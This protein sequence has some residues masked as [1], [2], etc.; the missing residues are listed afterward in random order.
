MAIPKIIHS[1]WLGGAEK[2]ALVKRCEASWREHLPDYTFME[3]NERNLDLDAYP[4]ARLMC[5]QKKWAFAIDPLRLMVLEKYGGI[6]MDV[7]VMVKKSFNPLLDANFIIGFMFENALGA[8]VVA[9]VPESRIVAELL[10]FYDGYRGE[11]IISNSIFTWY[12]V[13]HIEGFSLTGKTQVLKEG[14]HVYHRKYFDSPTYSPEM[15]YSVNENLGSWD[16]GER[17]RFPGW[18]KKYMRRLT[19]PV[20]YNDLRMRYALRHVPEFYPTYMLHKNGTRDYFVPNAYRSI[21]DRI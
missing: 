17:G 21:A 11:P 18:I 15:G 6:Y 8:G 1:I 13:K 19:G 7:D 3:W 9:S 16:G 14:V 4:Y 20:L 2:N 12:F 10:H 5:E